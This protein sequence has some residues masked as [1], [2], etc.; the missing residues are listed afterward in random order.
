MI[1]QKKKKKKHFRLWKQEVKKVEKNC[2]FQKGLANDFGQKFEI[3][4]R[5]N[6][7][8]IRPGNVFDEFI[9][10]KRAFFTL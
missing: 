7:S 3:F 9:E 4:P 5:L 6:F 8:E 2:I 1:C 10:R